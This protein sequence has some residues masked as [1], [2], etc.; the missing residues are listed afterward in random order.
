MS[1]VRQVSVII[2]CRNEAAT[3]RILLEGLLAQSTGPAALEV[4]IADGMSTDGTRDAV[5]DFARAHPELPLRLIDNPARTIPAALNRA[6]AASHAEVVLRLDAHSV[7]AQD[8]VARCLE[9]LA[10]SGAAN[11]GGQWEIRPSAPGAVGRSIAEA[12]SHPLGAGDARYRTGGQAGPVETVPFGAFPREWLER[13]GGYDETLLTNE[14]YELNLRLRRAGARVWFDPSIRSVYFARPTLLSLARQYARYG[15]WKGRM[16]LRYP[17][18]MRLRQAASPLWVL[19]TLGLVALAGWVPW[20]A[21]LL[22]LQWLVYLSVLLAV[23]ME[24][25]IRRRDAH[26]V[27]GLP[28]ALVTIHLTWGASFLWGVAREILGR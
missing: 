3:I 16:I 24:R 19:L 1:P 17:E 14:D 13:V 10:R 4:V 11:V 25:A 5:A 28:A 9:V 22:A 15:L 27:W 2:P 21:F 23:G 12:G 20:A 8:Y 18:S 6:I 7:P 26:L